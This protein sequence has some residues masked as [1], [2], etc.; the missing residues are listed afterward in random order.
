MPRT[1][2]SHFDE[3]ISRARALIEQAHLMPDDTLDQKSLREDILRSGIMFGVGAVDAYFCDAYAD[4]VAKILRAKTAQDHI[5][6]P[7]AIQ[8]ITLPVSALFHSAADRENW[9]WR[10]AARGIV[11]NDNV[12]SLFKIQQLFNP[13]FRQGHKLF[14]PPMIDNLIVSHNA[15]SRVTGMTRTEYRHKSGQSLHKARKSIKS[16]IKERYSKIFQRRHDC[17][18]NCDRPKRSLQ[19]ISYTKSEKAVTDLNLLVNIIDAHIENEFN[20][21]INR[22]GCDAVTRN[23]VQY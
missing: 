21:L 8:N 6:L 1:A 23:M 17:I 18:H 10:M 16:K 4:V 5:E 7:R 20:E 13:F 19:A 15:P 22:L 14:D 3:D 9:K 2:K 11:E 12:L